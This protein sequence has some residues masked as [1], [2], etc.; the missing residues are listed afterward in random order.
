MFDLD[1]LTLCADKENHERFY[2]YIKEHLVSPEAWKILKDMGTWF[3]SNDEITWSG[4][5][6]WFNLVAHPSHD[7][8]TKTLFDRIFKNL[9]EHD[10][11]EKLEDSLVKALVGRDYATRIADKA[12]AISEGSEKEKFEDIITLVEQY[13][14]EVDASAGIEDSIVTSDIHEIIKLTSGAVGY[15]W[16]IAQLNDAMGPVRKGKFVVVGSRPDTG[17]TSFLSSEATYMLKQMDED[18]KVL[19]F[20]NEE[21]GVDVKAR[22]VQAGTGWNPDDIEKNPLG[23]LKEF[24]TNAGDLDRIVIIDNASISTHTIEQTIKKH[25]PGLII[26]DQLWKVH[27]FHKESA[28]EVQRQTLLFNWGREVSKKYAPVITVHQ[29]GGAAG[30]ERWIPMEALYGSQTG[31]QG[32]ADA[33]ITIGRTYDP[34]EAKMRFFF[35]PKNK[36]RGKTPSQRN[37]RFICEFNPDNGRFESDGE[38]EIA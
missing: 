25:N 11:D 6:T 22:V 14:V 38:F 31:I 12:L 15:D 17:K 37:G 24:E 16:R 28:N 35:I 34:T 23:A 18:Q 29:C 36:M 26:F 20:N 32:E 2:P 5:S 19:W 3:N 10:L 21:S 27:G 1:I 7:A 9:D 4:F 33:I 8:K 30:G 13:E